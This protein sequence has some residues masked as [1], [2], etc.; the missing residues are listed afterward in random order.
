MDAIS[1]DQQARRIEQLE[2]D[3]FDLRAKL[4]RL[5]A[6]IER[7]EVGQDAARVHRPS[8]SLRWGSVNRP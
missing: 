2:R 5:A 8:P 1:A 6:R 7:L 4:E 3:A